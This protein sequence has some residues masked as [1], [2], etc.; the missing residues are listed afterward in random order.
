MTFRE[1][2]NYPVFILDKQTFSVAQGKA[3]DV[4]LPH[5]DAQR[6]NPS[7]NTTMVVDVTIEVDGKSTIYTISENSTVTY[8]GS[9]VLATNKEDI[10]KEINNM[11][12]TAQQI[13]D[14]VDKQKEI[15]EKAPIILAELNPELKEKQEAEKRLSN[16]E[17]SVIEMKDMM[18]TIL[19]KLK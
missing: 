6:P 18:S 14:S 19:S 2:K 12:I 15:I 11:V 10:T 1:I 8:A 17:S 9:L 16:L 4:S 5:F 7:I 3:V 13:I